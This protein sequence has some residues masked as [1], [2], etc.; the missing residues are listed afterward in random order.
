MNDDTQLIAQTL[1]GHTAAFGHLVEKYQDRL[2]NTVVHLVGN[3]EDAKDVVQEALVQA[4]LKLESFQ[5][6]SAFYTWA[7]RIAFNVAA[8]HRRH[9]SAM[10]SAEHAHDDG[11]DRAADGPEQRI[12]RDE[13]CRQ[14]RDA[15]AR[16]GEEQRA[17]LV[18]REIDGHDYATIA[19]ILELPIGTV[20]SRLHR[21]RSQ[22]R[23]QLK[24]VL[25][26]DQ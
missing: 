11:G 16:L 1:A 21:A 8:T 2:Y 12:D 20:R 23:E 19:E 22:L 17:V 15:I 6:A 14:V 24:Q 3:R 7:Y 26:I 25:T 4:F 10:R 9:R 5:G 13:Q 18:L